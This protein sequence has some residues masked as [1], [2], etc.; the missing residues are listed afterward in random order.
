MA[1]SLRGRLTLWSVLLMALIVGVIGVVDLGNEVQAQFDSSLDHAELLRKVVANL[2]VQTLERQRTAPLREALRDPNLSSELVDVLTASRTLL[3]IAVCDRNNEILADSDPGR[4][5][6]TFENYADFGP[7][8][9]NTTWWG[10]LQDRCSPTSATTSSSSRCR[11]PA[12]GQ[13]LLY[14]RVVVYPALIRNSIM[15]R[16]RKN[17][18][19]ALCFH[20]GRHHR[21]AA[22]LHH[23]LPPAGAARP[24]ARPAGARRVRTARAGPAAVPAWTSS[25]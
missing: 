16:L 23:R 13:T 18:A 9:T 7:L 15:P 14:V 3:E 1:M 10:K 4:L 11:Q 24:D 2:V 22:V 21:H 20:P 8:V 5:G 17:A 25:A 12:G 19:M 6:K